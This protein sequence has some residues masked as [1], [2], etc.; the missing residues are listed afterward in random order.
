MKDMDFDTG[1]A[2]VSALILI[3]L[4]SF[5]GAY[6]T[7]LI[8]NYLFTTTVLLTLFGVA[9]IGFWRA[10]VLNLLFGFFHTTSTRTTKK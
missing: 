5:L 9:K 7:M 10:F 8:V 4:L 2:A 1:L 6:F 3:G